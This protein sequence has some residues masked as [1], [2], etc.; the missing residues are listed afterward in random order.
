MTGMNPKKTMPSRTIPLSTEEFAHRA[1]MHF[2]RSLNAVRREGTL[3]K[4]R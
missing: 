3:S 2:P 4:E 1:V